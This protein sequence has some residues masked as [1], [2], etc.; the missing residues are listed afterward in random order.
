MIEGEQIYPVAPL[1]FRDGIHSPAVELFVERARAVVP[2]FSING[3]GD[4]VSEICRRLDGI[5]WQSS[6]RRHG[7][8]RWAPHRSARAWTT[9]FGF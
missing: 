4:D 9:V 1:G 8:A 2:D 7:F 6:L 5:P 3:H